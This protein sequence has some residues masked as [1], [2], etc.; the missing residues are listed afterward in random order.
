MSDL[1]R[2]VDLEVQ[3][4]IGVSE[5]ERAKPQRLLI[6]LQLS[7]DSFVRAA[8]RDDV[9]RTVDYVDV[10]KHVKAFVADPPRKLLETLVE[11]LAFDLLKN[12]PIK[13]IV[14]EIKKFVLP[15]AKWVAVEI[16]RHSGKEH[17]R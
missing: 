13:I 16:V 10:V 11:K 2:I 14:V 17:L 4:R 1:I 7:V 5:A 15:D 3:V 9:T 6:S 8:G 12:F